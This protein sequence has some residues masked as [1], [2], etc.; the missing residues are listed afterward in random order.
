MKHLLMV[1]A[2]LSI[3]TTLAARA[4]S[5]DDSVYICSKLTGKEDGG[6]PVFCM[7]LSTPYVGTAIT[8][9]ALLQTTIY[10]LDHPQKELLKA[11]KE[12][13][14]LF[15]YNEKQA[16][17]SAT[18]ISAL[19]VIKDNSPSLTDQEAALLVV[20]LNDSF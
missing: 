12:E 18:L 20:E 14:L 6:G 17:Q 4:A 3:G 13:A 10:Q 11:A 8:P 1:I 19:A 15:L 9:T 2:I 5:L 7:A 16:E